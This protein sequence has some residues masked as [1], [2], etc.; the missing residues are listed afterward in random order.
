MGNPDRKA[1]IIS[2]SNQ[3]SMNQVLSAIHAIQDTIHAIDYNANIRL[4]LET[5]MLDLPIVESQPSQ[6]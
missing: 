3:L 2:L 5:L 4:A 6:S 1:E